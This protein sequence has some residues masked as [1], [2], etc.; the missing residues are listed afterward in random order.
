MD[1]VI[2]SLRGGQNSTDPA[3]SLPEDQAILCQNVEF[4]DSLLG[5]RRLGTTAVTLPIFLSGKD[6]IPFIFRHLPTA[7]ETA[8]ELWALG[9]TGTTTASLGRKTSTW[10]TEVTISDTPTLTGFS[11]YRWQAVSLHGK[12]HFAYDSDKDRLHVWDGTTMR[13]SGMDKPGAAPTA[14]DTGGAGTLTGTR[15]GRVRYAELSG[16]TV[17]RRGEPSTTL[18]FAPSGTNAS[19]TWTKPATI[20]EGETHWE[21]ELST[22]NVNFY[23]MARI[24]VATTTHVDSVVFATGYSSTGTLSEDS[25]DYTL[26]PSARYLSADEDRLVW[27]GNWEDDA[28]ASRV[29]WTPV[30]R[31]SGSGNDE[32]FETDTDPFKDLDTYENGPITGLSAP[33]FG[34]IWAFKQ[35]GIYKLVRSGKRTA[36]YD[37]IKYTDALGAIHGSVVTGLDATGQPCVYFIDREQGPCRLGYGGIKR[38]GEDLR[39]IWKDINHDATKVVISSLYYP[40]KKQVIFCLATGSGNIPTTAIVLHADKSRDFDDGGRKGWTVWT[41]DRAKALTMC[42]YANNINDNVARNLVLVPLIGLEGLSLLHRC[43]TGNTDNAVAYTATI[44]T[45]P[46][47]LQNFLHQ[48]K[49]QGAAL[50]AKAVASAQIT[51]KCLRDFNIE[52]TTTVTDISLAASGTE[53]DVIKYLDNL[54]GAELRVAQFQFTDPTTVSAQWQLN[55]LVVREDRGQSA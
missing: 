14:A 26:I 15:Y 53:T 7:D 44:T 22:D 19:I 5:E 38:C 34:G 33:V 24:V 39:A 17:L 3:I 29:G 37:A 11:Q 43:D 30:F 4:F 40:K 20:S 54:T 46:Y 2:A 8:S 1:L 52:T 36:A 47:W 23:R 21:I 18:T 25:G 41:G 42:L 12:I 55:G 32:R 51:V 27:A 49:V 48:F 28:F 45:K 50:L 16:T 9:V 6:R 10:Q 13:R 31:A 35:H